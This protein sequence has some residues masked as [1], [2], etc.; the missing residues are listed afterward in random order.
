MDGIGHECVLGCRHFISRIGSTREYPFV[1][2][3][4][5]NRITGAAMQSPGPGK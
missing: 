2:V 3:G 1:F 4:V 5:E